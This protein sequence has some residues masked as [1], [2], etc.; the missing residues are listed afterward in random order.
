MNVEDIALHPRVPPG[1]FDL[2][3][4]L[5]HDPPT[6]WHPQPG[7]KLI[8][9]LVRLVDKTAFGT[10][11]PTLYVL[12]EDDHYRTVRASGV[13]LRGAIEDLKPAAGERVAVKFEG[14][15]ESAEGRRYALYRFAV[16][17]S[18]GWVVAA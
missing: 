2:T 5:E 18:G 8:G 12:T 11:A 10:T 6:R 4:L 15:R 3:A 16:K 17:R 1:E 9:E 13:V 7:E 14:F